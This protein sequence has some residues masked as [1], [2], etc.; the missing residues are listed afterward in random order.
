MKAAEVDGPGEIDLESTKTA[1]PS[2]ST[3]VRLTHLRNLEEK[4][5]SNGLYQ[6][7]FA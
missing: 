6:T 7:S 1:L 4:L 2:S 5:K 3:K